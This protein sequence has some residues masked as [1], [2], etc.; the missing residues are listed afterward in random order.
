MADYDAMT[1]VEIE[2]AKLALRQQI[3]A[4]RDELARAEEVRKRK[5]MNELAEEALASAG[6]TGVAVTPEPAALAAEMD[7]PGG[8]A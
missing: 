4:L 8:V 2:D 6:V 3:N 1:L 7:R 5:H